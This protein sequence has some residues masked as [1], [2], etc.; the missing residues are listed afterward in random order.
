MTESTILVTGAA[1]RAGRRVTHQLRSRGIK[2][3]PASRSGSEPFDWHDPRTW[4][5]AVDGCAAAY[6]C[7][8]PDLALPGVDAVIADF[9]AAAVDNGFR[10]IVL[11]SGRGEEGARRCEDIVLGAA[12]RARV[13]AT[14]VRCAWF[15]ENFSEHFLRDGV[16][17]GRIAVPVGTVAEPFVS[18]D[19][20]ATV[21]VHALTGD[22]HAG[23]VLELTGPE[24]ITFERAAR[25]LSAALG[26]EIAYRRVDVESF[27]AELVATGAD[28][29]EAQGIGWLVTEVLDGRNSATT[30]TV[31]RVLG[32]PATSFAEYA[33]R[34][35]AAGAW[36]AEPVGRR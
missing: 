12:D 2:V 28:P 35:A 29:A 31:E 10:R 15:Q 23:R 7:Y 1:G 11:L 8:S 30:D 36:S 21:A 27:V 19:D 13:T 9:T 22:G 24:S 6:L 17:N 5:A 34:A 32:R 14:V 26:R 20:V 18:L 16:L 25:V 3:R 33:R 4:P